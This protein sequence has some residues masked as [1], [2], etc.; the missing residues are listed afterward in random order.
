MLSR[1]WTSP[2]ERLD[3]TDRLAITK[4]AA[5]VRAHSDA[6]AASTLRVFT[7]VNANMTGQQMADRAR[8][9]LPEII[10][11]LEDEGPFVDGLYSSGLSNKWPEPAELRL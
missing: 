11:R 1:P 2:P 7:F 6:L 9:L 4:D 5:I 3:G 10:E 8:A